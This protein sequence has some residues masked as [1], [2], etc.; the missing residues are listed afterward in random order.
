MVTACVCVCVYVVHANLRAGR[1][2]VPMVH[3]LVVLLLSGFT[4]SDF[5]SVLEFYPCYLALLWP[6]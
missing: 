3:P 5:L 4:N 6:W 1:E 2:S